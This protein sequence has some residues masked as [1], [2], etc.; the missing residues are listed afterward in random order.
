MSELAKRVIVALII[1]PIAI[2]SAWFGDAALAALLSIV[3]GVAAWELCR[4]ARAKQVETIDGLAIAMAAALPLLAH[5]IR[6]GVLR[7]SAAWFALALLL[8]MTVTIFRRRAQRLDAEKER[9]SRRC[10]RQ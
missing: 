5:A 6:L 4:M 2:A 3:S 1:A 9:P 8:I 10:S 7:P